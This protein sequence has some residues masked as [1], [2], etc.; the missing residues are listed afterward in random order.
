MKIEVLFKDMHYEQC[1]STTLVASDP[2]HGLGVNV[3][4]EMN[5][6]LDDI[7]KDG[8]V[9]SINWYHGRGSE[10]D[11]VDIQGHPTPVAA[12]R[13]GCAILLV[14]SDE[15][16]DLVWLKKDGDK[17]LWREGNE[18]INGEKFFA[19]EQLCFSDGQCI[20][21]STRALR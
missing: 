15:V 5:L 1:D 8:I 4:T 19:M 3:L 20:S 10:Q 9:L 13:T 6:Y 12:R 2:W 16:K 21:I 11:T 17:I 7:E 18:L 14:S